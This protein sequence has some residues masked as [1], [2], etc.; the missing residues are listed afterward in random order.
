MMHRS[1]GDR[2]PLKS[3]LSA[4]VGLGLLLAAATS[5]AYGTDG[6]EK[7]PGIGDIL[8]LLDARSPQALAGV[9]RSALLDYLPNPLYDESPGWGRKRK[10]RR[11]RFEGN[12]LIRRPKVVKVDQNH[13]T[14]RHIK[15]TAIR[16][17]DTLVLDIRNVRFPKPGTMTFDIFLAFDARGEFTQQNWERGI[18]LW[19]GTVRA[20]FRAQVYMNCEATARLVPGKN[21][22]IPDA[23]FRLRAT[24]AAFRYD[25]LVYEH[26]P[27]IGGAAARILGKTFHRMLDTFRPSLERRM[28]ERA[29]AA[30]VRAADTGEVRIS[31]RRVF[32]KVLGQ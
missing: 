11:I 16:P 4:F 3:F 5:P 22:L 25:N 15:L 26:V 1:P 23:S 14:W 12:G 29:N 8:P 19:S 20:R 21:Q 9:L 18:R 30:I 27:G 2:Q 7:R 6:K 17:K 13:G 32:S 31:L 28:L 24:N 10:V